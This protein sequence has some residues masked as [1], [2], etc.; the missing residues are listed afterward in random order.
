MNEEILNILQ[1]YGLS[2]TESIIYLTILK[3]GSMTAYKIS[4]EAGLYK[5]NTYQAVETL[6]K[7]GIASEYSSDKKSFIRVLPPEELINTIERQKEQ[8]QNILPLMERSFGDEEGIT[9]LKGI[10]SFMNALYGFLDFKK[11]IFVWDIPIY[12]PEKVAPYINHFHKERIKRK[13]KMWHVYDYDA[14]DRIK[15]LSKMRYT[16]AK[17][18]AIDR[19]STVSTLTCGDVTLIINWTKEVKTIMIKDKDVAEAFKGQFD[20]LWEK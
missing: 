20:M 5:A 7:K 13:V 2:R 17:R 11:D 18:G 3:N 4:K 9:I 19:H 14:Q 6:I 1:K 10:Q 15:Y 16:Y 12:V 8:L